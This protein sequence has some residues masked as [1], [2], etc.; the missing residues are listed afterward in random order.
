MAI[1]FKK[2]RCKISLLLSELLSDYQMV[3]MIEER[4]REG[5]CQSTNRYTKAD[6]RYM[7]NYDKKIESSY[8]AYLHANNLHGLNKLP[9]NGFMWYNDHL[10]DFNDFNKKITMKIMMKVIFLKLT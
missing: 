8:L 2:Y 1:L 7:K 3:L 5:M 10:L 4:I 9:V 6:N